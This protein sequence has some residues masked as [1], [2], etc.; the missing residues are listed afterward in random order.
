MAPVVVYV[1]L[2]IAVLIHFVCAFVPTAEL[3]ATVFSGVTVTVA[4]LVVLHPPGVVTVTLY[5]VVPVTA[6]A[7]VGFVVVLERN[8]AGDHK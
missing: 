6:V 3:R 4:L 5:V 1:I 8:V 2:V 7:V